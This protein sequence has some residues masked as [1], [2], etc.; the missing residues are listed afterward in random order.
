MQIGDFKIITEDKHTQLDW[1]WTYFR[2]RVVQKAEKKEI[3]RK[4]IVIVCKN[5]TVSYCCYCLPKICFLITV[6]YLIAG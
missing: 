5:W 3:E 1:N 4:L 6:Y 2:L